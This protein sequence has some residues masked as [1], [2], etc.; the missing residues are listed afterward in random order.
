MYDACI[1]VLVLETSVLDI[2]KYVANNRVFELF[3][4]TVTEKVCGQLARIS[5]VEEI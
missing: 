2:L 5:C 1:S 4:W 3:G